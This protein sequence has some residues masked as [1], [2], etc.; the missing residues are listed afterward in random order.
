MKTETRTYTV[1][2]KSRFIAVFLVNYCFCALSALAEPG[3]TDQKLIVGIS[4]PLS[5]SLA[6][7][8]VDLY[9]GMQLGLMQIN[10]NGGI[11]GRQIELMVRDDAGLTERATANTRELLAAGVL[12]ITG[13]Y[14]HAAI[15]AALP[16]W[17]AAG[18]PIIGV[19]S[20]S[21][22]LREPPR[23][24]LF[25]LRAG[26]RDESIAMVLHLDTVGITEVAV[27][28]QD[29]DTGRA[30]LESFNNEL[31][32][33]AILPNAQAQ[34]PVNASDVAVAKAVQIVCKTNPQAIVLLLDASSALTVI[35]Q[36]RKKNCA[37]Q[38]YVMSAAGT[39]I[40]AGALLPGDMTGVVVS[41]VLPSPNAV[42][43][44][45]VA[46]FRRLVAAQTLSAT[47]S[48]ATLEGFVYARVIVEALKRCTREPSRRCLV[49]ALESRPIDVGGYRVQFHTNDRRGSKFVE[50]TIVTPDGRFRR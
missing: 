15:E 5:G 10:A 17:D 2:W 27:I 25:N 35:R 13:Y 49:K 36:A 42:K 28:T 34:L 30:G 19:A 41:Q 46:D 32:R 24:T 48:Y 37:P 14:G 38:F 44:P 23:S 6:Q 18:V 4:T 16:L 11:A 3:V 33:L 12:A 45:L 40:L 50:M 29:S 26:A 7:Y 20:E 1:Q 43:I 8:G 47:P 21:E 31:V 39:Q 9:K 22:G